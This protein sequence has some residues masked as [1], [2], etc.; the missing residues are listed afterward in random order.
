VTGF[1]EAY[2]HIGYICLPDHVEKELA[3]LVTIKK[4]FLVL[5]LG[6]LAWPAYALS[7]G[8]IKVDSALNQPL[9][10]E[11]PIDDAEPTSLLDATVELASYEEHAQFGI[12]KANVLGQLRFKVVRNQQG[13]FVIRLTT[14]RAIREPVLEFV[15]DVSNRSSK[16][17]RSYAIHL[18]PP[19]F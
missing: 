2:H 12:E 3:M 5:V 8:E 13:Q 9:L 10:A 6:M 19:R 11:I 18:D 7:L 16:L 14:Q 4:L 17:R 15:L 1:P